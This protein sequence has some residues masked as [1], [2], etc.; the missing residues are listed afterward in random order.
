[1]VLHGFYYIHVGCVLAVLIV[2]WGLSRH[3]SSVFNEV[4]TN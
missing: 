1:M 4:S 2:K 3:G